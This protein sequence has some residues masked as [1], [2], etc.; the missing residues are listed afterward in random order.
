MAADEIWH[1]GD[2]LNNAMLLEFEKLGKTIRGVWGN[3]DPHEM[4]QIFP[5][6]NHFVVEQLKCYMTHIG[7]F[8]GKYGKAALQE[9]RSHKP[10]LFVCGHSH[11]LR[12]GRD[13]LY[14]NL[15]CINPGACGLQGFHMVRTALRFK[16]HEGKVL[17]MEAIEF[18]TR[19]I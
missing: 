3:A 13:P 7:G 8:P 14:N 4:R 1:T 9:I 2:W 15:L 6:H 11:I 17:D 5:E 19:K 12:V 18:G 16:I 10:Q